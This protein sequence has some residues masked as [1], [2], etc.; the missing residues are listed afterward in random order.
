MCPR[1]KKKR[2]SA[3][4]NNNNNNNSQMSMPK[5]RFYVNLLLHYV[6]L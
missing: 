4:E 6:M 3:P 1:K 2:T 5:Y